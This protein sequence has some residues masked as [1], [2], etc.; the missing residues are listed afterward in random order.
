MLYII[1]LSQLTE[2]ES[3]IFIWNGKKIYNSGV[4]YIL[5]QYSI[6]NKYEI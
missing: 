3:D 2:D 4:I 6:N 1:I 5:Y